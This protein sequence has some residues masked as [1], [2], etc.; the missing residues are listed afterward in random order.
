MPGALF[1]LSAVAERLLISA[2]IAESHLRQ[3]NLVA[4][5]QFPVK[6]APTVGISLP[7]QF[8]VPRERFGSETK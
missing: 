7:V 3:L 2:E 4:A 1:F 6:P 8:F 5:I